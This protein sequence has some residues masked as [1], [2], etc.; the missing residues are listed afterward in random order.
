MTLDRAEDASAIPVRGGRASVTSRALSLLGTFNESRRQM[1]LSEMAERAGLPLPTA[2]RLTRELVEWGALAR[3]QNGQYVIGRRLWDLGSLAPVQRGLVEAASPYLHDLYGATRATV[4]LAVRDG[5]RAL[6]LE[7][8]RGTA[9]VPVVSTVGSRLPL[10]TTGVGK[11]L[12]AY[13][14]PEV[15]DAVCS[16]LSRIT[17]YTVDSP[18]KLRRQMSRVREDGYATTD[19]EMTLGACS[20]AVPVH[21]GEDVVAA[22][23]VVVPPPGRDRVRMI[24]ALEVAARGIGRALR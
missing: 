17:A 1:A 18:A 23:G 8:L 4:Q 13:A 12:L 9:S 14:P 10:H 5:E 11:V 22:L 21:R 20:M 19:E 15:L 6:Y 16:D 24:A 7:R 3:L 2:L